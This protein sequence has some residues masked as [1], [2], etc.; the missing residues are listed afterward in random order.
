MV[1]R[2]LGRVPDTTIIVTQ[3]RNESAANIAK[4]NVMKRLKYEALGHLKISD[5]KVTQ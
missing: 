4:S 3:T 2:L 1:R 5:V